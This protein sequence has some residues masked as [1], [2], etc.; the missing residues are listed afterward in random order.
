MRLRYVWWAG[1]VPFLLAGMIGCSSAP[2]A[3]TRVLRAPKGFP[4]PPGGEKAT[5]AQHTKR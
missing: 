4:A 3:P 1:V 2:S 5:H